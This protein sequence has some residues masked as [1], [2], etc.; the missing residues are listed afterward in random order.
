MESVGVASYQPTTP[1]DTTVLRNCSTKNDRS[2]HPA[3]DAVADRIRKRYCNQPRWLP[4]YSP[5]GQSP[6]FDNRSPAWNT[7]ATQASKTRDRWKANTDGS[8]CSDNQG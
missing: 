3:V 1:R 4:T 5:F 8:A 2:N 6:E 7:G